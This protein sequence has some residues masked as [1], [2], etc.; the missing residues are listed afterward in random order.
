MCQWWW[1]VAFLALV[2][3]V[4]FTKFLNNCSDNFIFWFV[5]ALYFKKFTKVK[6]FYFYKANAYIYVI[7]GCQVL[8]KFFIRVINNDDYIKLYEIII[9]RRPIFSSKEVLIGID[10]LNY[11]VKITSVNTNFQNF[12]ILQPGR[13]SFTSQ[14]YFMA[15][16]RLQKKVFYNKFND[17]RVS[18]EPLGK[19]SAFSCDI[20]SKI[21]DSALQLKYKI[22][23]FYSLKSWFLPHICFSSV[24]Y[25]ILSFI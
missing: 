18:E 14:G 20:L 15:S 5:Y 17:K 16:S 13:T 23:I 22:R 24:S 21:A 4:K 3:R 10:F 1:T 12:L 25:C 8:Y 11:T 9:T 2:N 19:T 6:Y 7:C